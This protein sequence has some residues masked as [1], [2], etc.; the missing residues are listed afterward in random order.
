[1]DE[2]ILAVGCEIGVAGPNSSLGFTMKSMRR[3]EAGQAVS[4]AALL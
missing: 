4:R 1:M 3:Q 2:W